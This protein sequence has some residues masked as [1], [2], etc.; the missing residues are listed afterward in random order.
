MKGS[1]MVMERHCDH[2]LSHQSMWNQG[3]HS[4]HLFFFS[5]FFFFFWEGVAPVAYGAS[6]AR[7]QI[8]AVA[9]GLSH[10]HSNTRSEPCLQLTPQL[11]AMW[12]P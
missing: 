4:Y 11:T 9:A 5:F 2:L 8:G 7:G 1:F 10:S 6:Q 3:F 12:D